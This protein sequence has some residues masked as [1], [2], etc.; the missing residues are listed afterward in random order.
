MLVQGLERQLNLQELPLLLK[1]T[2]IQILALIS[3]ASQPPVTSA[4]RRLTL[5]LASK[6]HPTDADRQI[7]RQTDTH[8]HTTLKYS[9]VVL[10]ED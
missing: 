4:P 8:S 7:D 9:P 2:P 6:G 10:Q 1:K 3:G 5:P